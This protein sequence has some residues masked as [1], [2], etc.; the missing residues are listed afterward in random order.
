[1]NRARTARALSVAAAADDEGRALALHRPPRLRPGRVDRAGAQEGEAGLAPTAADSMLD[2]E[3]SGLARVGEAGIEIERAPDGV[4]FEAL[5]AGPPAAAFA[6][7]LG[8][9]VRGAQCGPLATRLAGARSERRRARAAAVRTDRER[10]RGR[11]ALLA[12]AGRRRA[13]EPLQRDRGVRVARS[14]SVRVLK[15]GRR[16]RR[17]AGSEGRVRLDPEPLAARPGTS[18]RTTPASSATPSSTG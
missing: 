14:G 13:G 17:P 16:D 1:M 2:L 11:F 8:R 6:G 4:R 15:R 10:G 7:R 5:D 18:P 9:E 12:P 3:V